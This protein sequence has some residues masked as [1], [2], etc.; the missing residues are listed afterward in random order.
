MLKQKNPDANAGT[1]IFTNSFGKDRVN[2]LSCKAFWEK[3]A[4]LIRTMASA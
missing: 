3:V 1:L 2:I 4:Q